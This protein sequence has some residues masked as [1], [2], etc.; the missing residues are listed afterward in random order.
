M[1][2]LTLGCF[3]I[4]LS[5]CAMMPGMVP[6]IGGRTVIEREFYD[7]DSSYSESI[8]APAGVDVSEL[9]KF[10]MKYKDG[11]GV[12][13]SVGI[14]AEKVANTEAQAQLLMQISADTV[15]AFNKLA[16]GLGALIPLLPMSN[17]SVKAPTPS[18]DGE[19]IRAVLEGLR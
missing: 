17:V 8:K 18:V 9:S 4:V 11:T 15:Q 13:Y 6:G 2:T 10:T 1:K 16:E 3:A 7:G 14:D 19:R 12:D 5:G